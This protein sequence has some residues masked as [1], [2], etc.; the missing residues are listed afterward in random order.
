MTNKQTP[1]QKNKE[2]L[3]YLHDDLCDKQLANKLF[4][5]CASGRFIFCTWLK[6]LC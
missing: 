1:K 4:A 2:I 6:S 3:N 5:L